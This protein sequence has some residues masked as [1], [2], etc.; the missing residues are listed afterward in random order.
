MLDVKP[1]QVTIWLF[2]DAV[3]NRKGSNSSASWLRC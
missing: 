1:E 2:M 3:H